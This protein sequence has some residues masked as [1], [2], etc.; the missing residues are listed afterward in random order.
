MAKRKSP[1]ISEAFLQRVE[2][3]VDHTGH[4]PTVVRVIV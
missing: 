4:E 3:W 1:W 2:Y